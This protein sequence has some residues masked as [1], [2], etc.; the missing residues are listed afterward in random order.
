M[1]GFYRLCGRFR[2]VGVS[3]VRSGAEGAKYKRLRR[4]W[5]LCREGGRVGE[6]GRQRV[7]QR[8][9]SAVPGRCLMVFNR[10]LNG[11]GCGVL[12]GNKTGGRGEVGNVLVSSV[13]L[14]WMVS[15]IVIWVFIRTYVQTP[16]RTENGKKTAIF[17][18]LTPL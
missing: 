3:M 1:A 9:W 17:E 7:H 18:R 10:V 5:G 8:E 16:L 13:K 15:W 14:S 2:C 4:L 11:S 12:R 6:R